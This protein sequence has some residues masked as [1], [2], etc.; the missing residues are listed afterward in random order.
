MSRDLRN[1]IK[2]SL[3]R[4]RNSNGS[5]FPRRCKFSNLSQTNFG[6]SEDLIN[7]CNALF[8]TWQLNCNIFDCLANFIMVTNTIIVWLKFLFWQPL[9]FR[10]SELWINIGTFNCTIRISVEIKESSALEFSTL[11]LT[12]DHRNIIL[13]HSF[14]LKATRNI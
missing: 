3:E 4:R 7:S 1:N 2:G 13:T 5:H 14:S 6:S 10:L 8:K 9:L 12:R 11:L